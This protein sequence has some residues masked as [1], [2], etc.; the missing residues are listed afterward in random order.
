MSKKRIALITVCV[1]VLVACI[2]VLIYYGTQEKLPQGTK[3]YTV[4]VVVQDGQERV[5]N[6]NTQE[7]FLGPALVAQNLIEGEQGPYGLYIVKV[8][9][10]QADEQKQEWWCLTKGGESVATGVDSTPVADGDVFELTLM[11]G[12]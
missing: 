2:S 3:Q 6:L 11:T 8:N 12:W 5:F 1:V 9:D 4:K 10:V 7:E